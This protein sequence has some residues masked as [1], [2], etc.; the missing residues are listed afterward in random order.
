MGSIFEL[1]HDSGRLIREAGDGVEPDTS[2]EQCPEAKYEDFFER[3]D[4]CMNAAQSV[5][6][7]VGR[8]SCTGWELENILSKI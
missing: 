5:I 6:D 7:E 8:I 2:T 3:Y 4:D 1:G